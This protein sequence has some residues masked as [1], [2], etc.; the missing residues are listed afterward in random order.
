MTSTGQFL[1]E[2]PQ[3]EEECKAQQWA[4]VPQKLIVLKKQLLKTKIKRLAAAA[5]SSNKKEKSKSPANRF[6]HDKDKPKQTHFKK[7]LLMK[8]GRTRIKR[9]WDISVDVAA[10]IGNDQSSAFN[11]PSQ[12]RKTESPSD[13]DT[14][15]LSLRTNSMITEDEDAILFKAID[16]SKNVSEVI[17]VTHADIS[18]DL[19]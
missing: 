12:I 17:E 13:K 4:S 11:L 2:P 8:N 5:Q 9:N 19:P 6:D 1:Q 7:P 16:R 15:K 14:K 10:H 18:T 3:N